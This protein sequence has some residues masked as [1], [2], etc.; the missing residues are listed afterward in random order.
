A[1]REVHGG[2][3]K[4]IYAYG[5]EDIRW[6]EQKLGRALELSAVGENLTTSGIDVTNAVIGEQWAIGEALL[7]V[8]QPRSPCWKLGVKMGDP[9]FP[10]KF[11]QAERPGAYLRIAREGVLSPGDRIEVVEK[12]L[13][14]VRVSD[15][16]RIFTRERR[17]APLLLS[18]P[19]LS[20]DW[21]EWARRVNS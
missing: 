6:W 3:D 21:K 10:K 19:E 16:F 13:H 8:S 12:P 20:E 9:G 14:G 15:V 5:I 2:P 18:V 11:T 4:A 7:E 1:D 17:K